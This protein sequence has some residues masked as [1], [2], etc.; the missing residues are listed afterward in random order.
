MA[1]SFVR[2]ANPIW[3]F[4]DL[5]G[6][7]LNDQY[8]AFFVQNDFPY[9]PYAGG[10]VFANVDGSAPWPV[11]IQFYPN[12]TLPDNLYFN[13]SLVYRIE[14]RKGNTQADPL[15]YEINNF[16]PENGAGTLATASPISENQISNG[17]FTQTSFVSPL[18]ITSSGTYNIAPDWQLIL[19]GTGTATVTKIA[20]NGADVNVGNPPYALQFITAGWTGAVLQQTF[21]NNGGIFATV[22]G[23]QYGIIYT[24]L[25]AEAIDNNYP[26]T[27]LYIPSTT[28]GPSIPDLMQ[29]TVGQNVYQEFDRAIVLT[30]S[31]NV[32]T[33]DIASVTIQI[34]LQNNGKINIAGISVSGQSTPWSAGSPTPSGIYF[35]QETTERQIDH[36]FHYYKD[37]LLRQPKDSLLTGWQ[38]G[39]NPWQ[40]TT[41]A[42]TNVL[43]NRYTADQTIIIQQGF[44]TGAVNNNVAVGQGTAAQNRAFQ[45]SAVT[46]NNE[47]AILQY[48]DPYTIGPYWGQVVS[49]MVKAKFNTAHATTAPKIKMLLAY[50]ST[51]PALATQL[52]PV[53]TWTTGD[54]PVFSAGWTE[55]KCNNDP[56]YQ[57]TSG[58]AEY[59]FDGFQLPA[60][61]G[62]DMTLAV[63]VYTVGKTNQ[64]SVADFVLFEDVSLIPND[65]SL[66]SNQLTWDET[67]RR[68]QYYYEKSYDY[69]T[70]LGNATA[71]G[72]KGYNGVLVNTGS[73]PTFFTQMYGFGFEITYK[74]TKREIPSMRFWSPNT[75]T[76]DKV[77]SSLYIHTSATNADF[78]FS[79]NYNIES[80]STDN[81]NIT[82]TVAGLL[83]INSSGSSSF[84]GWGA[85]I[86]LHYEADSRLG[87]A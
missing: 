57:L 78:T 15:I 24:S 60:S 20:L 85:S 67:L 79:T 70:L 27:V 53:A 81:A 6:L 87:R 58:I 10:Q 40:F 72:R 33:S 18:S 49:S 65:F 54:K 3:F 77:Q 37:A 26:L 29:V 21:H 80:Q 19:T 50:R 63:M 22:T 38:F 64:A 17:Q 28:S 1:V 2:A 52:T 11:P 12:G 23:Q 5:E 62:D 61:I 56:A 39:M 75:G 71:V 9:L 8:Y 83:L 14:I 84:A 41:T 86:F 73:S 66:P 44:V 69:G 47:F 4:V 82:P 30:A 46:A 68:C 13:N 35:P 31:A 36:L 74:Q 25:I 7:P 43:D 34:T 42:L 76:V 32:Q 45:V 48:I 59:A 55:I 51:L 16:V